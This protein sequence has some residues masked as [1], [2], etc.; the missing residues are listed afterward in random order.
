MS[1][2]PFLWAHA[3]PSRRGQSFRGLQVLIVPKTIDLLEDRLF[4]QPRQSFLIRSTVPRPPE[5]IM[6]IKKVRNNQGPG[7]HGPQN[8]RKK[9]GH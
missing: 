9:N 5:R 3:A 4:E 6:A 8:L 2:L 7:R 1:Y